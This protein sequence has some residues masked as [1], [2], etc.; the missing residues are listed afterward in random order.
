MENMIASMICDDSNED[1]I[2]QYMM[3]IV[4][5]Y[6]LRHV[7]CLTQNSSQSYKD[8]VVQ[9]NRGGCGV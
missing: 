4:F 1:S 7:D 8:V 5:L 2:N 3:G 9:R 6:L